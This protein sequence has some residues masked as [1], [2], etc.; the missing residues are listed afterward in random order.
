MVK[1]FIILTVFLSFLTSDSYYVKHYYANGNKKEEGWMAQNKKIKY[2]FYYY[3]NGNKREEGHYSNDK[4]VDWWILYDKKGLVIK[5]ME[6]KNNQPNGFAFVYESDEVVK[7]EK[8]LNGKMMQ[9]WTSM[10]SFKKDNPD[11]FKW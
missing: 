5:K 2:W 8:F 6:Y 10:E 7:A 3:E 4:K 11:F 1:S 9:E